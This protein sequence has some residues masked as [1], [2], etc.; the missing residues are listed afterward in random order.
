MGF[1]AFGPAQHGPSLIGS[2]M[3]RWCSSWACRSGRAGPTTK[4]LKAYKAVR[5]DLSKQIGLTN[6]LN[7]KLIM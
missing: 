6:Y 4:Y 3:G 2:C 7:H 5:M 1:R